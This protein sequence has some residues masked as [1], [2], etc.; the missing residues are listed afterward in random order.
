VALNYLQCACMVM[1]RQRPRCSKNVARDRGHRRLVCL[2]LEQC[3]GRSRVQG[4]RDTGSVTRIQRVGDR[5][6]GWLLH[7]AEHSGASK[8]WENDEQSGSQRTPA[9]GAVTEGRPT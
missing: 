4:L 1:V 7:G 2:V 9:N 8:I 6:D 5:A 3:M